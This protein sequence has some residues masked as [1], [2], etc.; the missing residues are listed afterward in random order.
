MRIR[1]AIILVVLA[2]SALGSIHASAA[3]TATVTSTPAAG[4]P[5]SYY[6]A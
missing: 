4:S 2:L 3:M 1:R 5:L 6:H